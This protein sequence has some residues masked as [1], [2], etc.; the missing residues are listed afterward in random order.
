MVSLVSLIWLVVLNPPLPFQ[1]V[2]GGRWMQT[3]MMDSLAIFGNR[4]FTL[5]RERKKTHLVRLGENESIV[6][7]APADSHLSVLLLI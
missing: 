7:Y 6:L 2:D 4:P 3:W 1:R 5:K